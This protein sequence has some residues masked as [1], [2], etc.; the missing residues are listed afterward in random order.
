MFIAKSL[1]QLRF[2][3]YYIYLAL[4]YINIMRLFEFNKIDVVHGSNI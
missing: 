1:K 4:V 3:G 2:N